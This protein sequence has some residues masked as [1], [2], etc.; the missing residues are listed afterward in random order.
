MKGARLFT[1]TA[2]AQFWDQVAYV[3]NALAMSKPEATNYV[4]C[5]VAGE[6]A[7]D[8]FDEMGATGIYKGQMET[9]KARN[10]KRLILDEEDVVDFLS[11]R[12]KTLWNV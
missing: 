7:F 10:A 11:G 3:E 8:L 1:E 2:G 4:L 12:Y 6:N 5:V 9:P